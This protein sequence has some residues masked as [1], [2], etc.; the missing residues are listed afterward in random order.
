MDLEKEGPGEQYFWKVRGMPCNAV[1]DTYNFDYVNGAFSP[2][3]EV[4]V[5]STY[6]H[7]LFMETL[8]RTPIG[9]ST[10]SHIIQG[11]LG[12][13]HIIRYVLSICSS[14]QMQNLFSI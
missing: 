4:F 3:N 7:D 14:L 5:Y 6:T 1:G 8:G 9:S 2:L 10:E 11:I 13:P 12:E